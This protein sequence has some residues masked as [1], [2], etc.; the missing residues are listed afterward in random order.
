MWLQTQGG[1]FEGLE[2]VFLLLKRVNFITS[3]WF[4]KEVILRNI[5]QNSICLEKPSSEERLKGRRTI[6]PPTIVFSC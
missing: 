5:L 1:S 4:L 3:L 2:T 6:I